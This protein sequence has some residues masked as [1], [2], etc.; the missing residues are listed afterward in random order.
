[1]RGFVIVLLLIGLIGG[2]GYAVR[3]YAPQ[4]LP[5]QWTSDAVLTQRLRERLDEDSRAEAFFTQFEALFPADYDELMLQLVRLYRRGGT[6]Q[7]AFTLG[8]RYMTSFIEDNQQHVAA[9]EPAQLVELGQAI[10]QGTTLLRQENEAV[11]GEAFR[12]QRGFNVPVTGMSQETQDAFTRIS[13][14]MLNGIASGKRTP[15]EYAAPSEAQWLAL[16]T[17]YEAVGGDRAALEA[18]ASDAQM[19]TLPAATVCGMVERLWAAAVQ[20]E[21][22]FVPRFVSHSMRQ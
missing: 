2:G 3:E 21:D 9:A 16:V 14:A 17:R 13:L 11:C 20:A 19:R 4:Y 15:T 8:E 10:A 1:M 6:Q 12:S 5:D 7:Q 22:D 18:S